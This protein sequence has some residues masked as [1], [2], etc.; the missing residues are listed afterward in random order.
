M[1]TSGGLAAKEEN[2]VSSL[3]ERGKKTFKMEEMNGEES[4]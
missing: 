3:P 1:K 2:T 4:L